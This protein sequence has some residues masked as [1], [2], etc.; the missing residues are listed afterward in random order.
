MAQQITENEY[1]NLSKGTSTGFILNLLISSQMSMCCSLGW[2]K[3]SHVLSDY[4]IMKYKSSH[5]STES[6]SCIIKVQLQDFI[7]Q[8]LKF[9]KKVC[10]FR[11]FQQLPRWWLAVLKSVCLSFNKADRYIT[12]HKNSFDD[13]TFTSNSE[14]RRQARRGNKT[15]ISVTTAIIYDL[16]VWSSF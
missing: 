3:I 10:W 13:K 16:F 14:Y 12:H 7:F 8:Q 9:L 2:N 1:H 6:K 4:I 11:F 15:W 5:D